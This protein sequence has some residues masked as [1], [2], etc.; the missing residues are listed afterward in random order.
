MRIQKEEKIVV[1]LLLMALGSLAV[2]SWAFGPEETGGSTVQ[3]KEDSQISLEGLVQ[4][5]NPTKTGGHLIIKLDSTQMSVFVP[6]DSGAGDVQ[7][8]VNIGDR[9]RV[10][11]IAAEFGGKKELKVGRAADIEVL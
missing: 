11:G 5:I 3:S 10:K 1:V 8:R 6:R 4:E 2:A 9:I 7:S